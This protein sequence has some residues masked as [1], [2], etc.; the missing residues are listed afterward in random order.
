M[1]IN[2]L[3]ACIESKKINQSQA[4]EAIYRVL[5]EAEDQCFCVTRILDELSR[6]YPKKVSLNTVY[7]HLNLFVSCKLAVMIQDDYKKAYYCL[8]QEEPSAFI[9]CTKCNRV[10][11]LTALSCSLTQE[12][13][14]SEFITIHKRCQK[15]TE[16]IK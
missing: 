15:C 13:K 7:R 14:D 16:R 1:G 11:K 12:F 2:R 3:Y 6:V 8:T 4:R 10:G 9:I 5:T